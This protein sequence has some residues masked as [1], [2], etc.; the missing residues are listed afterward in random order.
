MRNK[1]VDKFNIRRFADG[2][3]TILYE[4]YGTR[5]IEELTKAQLS[6][7]VPDI[8]RLYTDCGRPPVKLSHISKL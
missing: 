4:R 8:K 7:V 5:K 3:K 6:E 2:V 1:W